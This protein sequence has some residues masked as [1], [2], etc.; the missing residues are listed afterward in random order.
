M[1]M[2]RTIFNI[3]YT[4]ILAKRVYCVLSSE[5][6]VES[7]FVYIGAIH[8]SQ[9]KGVSNIHKE[10]LTKMLQFDIFNKKLYLNPGA[11][12]S[13]LVIKG[14]EVA[15][16]LPV[17]LRNHPVDDDDVIGNYVD[18]TVID[19]DNDE[20]TCHFCTSK[21]SVGDPQVLR[22]CRQRRTLNRSQRQRR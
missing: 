16:K 8:H 6:N 2:M 3:H 10:N 9:F 19:D 15:S 14:L 13:N 4:H 20:P 7:D 17:A 12:D 22:Q 11:S 1:M 21:D 5:F 18:D